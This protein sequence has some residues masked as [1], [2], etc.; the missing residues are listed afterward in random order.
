MKKYLIAFAALALAACNN[1]CY[2][3]SLGDGVSEADVKKIVEEYIANN[4]DKLSASI[5]NHL[6]QEQYNQSEASLK[7]HS[8]LRGEEDAKV[9]L[10]EFGDYRC[11]YCRLVQETLTKVREEYSDR[12][13]F[14]FKFMPILSEESRN[15][16]FAAHAAGKQGKF[17]EF[18][19]ALWENQS[20]LGDE[21]YVEL[22]EENGLDMD[23]F[24]A[25][26]KSQ[27]VQQEVY[28][29]YEDGQRFGASGTPFFMINGVPLSGAQPYENFKKA[30]DEALSSVNG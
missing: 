28:M 6:T 7:N 5:Q 20:R 19:T 22:A 15:A 17:W 12:V 21:L 2:G 9:T 14:S 30:L 18:H 4:G 26:R 27:E 13:K 8:P 11:G 29:D 16:A 3:F 10:I 24:N 25:D 23:K 1:T